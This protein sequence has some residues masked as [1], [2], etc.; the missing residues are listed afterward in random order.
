M[1]LTTLPSALLSVFVYGYENKFETFRLRKNVQRAMRGSDIVGRG[2][3]LSHE[4]VCM[5]RAFSYMK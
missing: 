5:G 2:Q 3:K 4:P 1:H